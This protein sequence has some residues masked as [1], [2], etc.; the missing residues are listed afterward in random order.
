MLSTLSSRLTKFPPNNNQQC[1][2][3]NNKI[4]HHNHKISLSATGTF[5]YTAITVTHQ[6]TVVLLLG[7][8]A[9]GVENMGILLLDVTTRNHH[10][11]N[12]YQTQDLLATCQI[13][14]QGDFDLVIHRDQ[15]HNN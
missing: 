13:S 11:C 9:M 10:N 6:T 12:N 8:S 3:N 5:A 4:R 14:N 2:P 1:L 15:D 7:C